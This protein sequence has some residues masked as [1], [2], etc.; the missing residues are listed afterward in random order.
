[1]DFE[2]DDNSKEIKKNGKKYPD[3][4]SLLKLYRKSDNRKAV[5]QL[6]NTLVPYFCLW[7]LMILSIRFKFPYYCTLLLA[8]PSS[9]F[10]VRIFILFHDCVHGSF[11]TSRKWNK[12]LGYILGVLVFTS[13][14]DWRFSHLKHHAN[15]GNLDARGYG[16]IWTLT[17]SEYNSLTCKKKI[18]YRLYRTPA[19]FILLGGFYT[20]FLGNRFPEKRVKFKDRKGVL[21]T[22]LIILVI[23]VFLSF[24]IGVKTYLLI[25]VPVLW[26]AGMAG[27]W[28][29]YVQ[30][31]FEGVYWA[32]ESE[33]DLF[34]A[35]MEG[36]SFYKLPA[37]L[38]WFSGNIG[39]HH[40]HHL[41]PAIPNYFL[42]KCYD[43][44]PPLQSKESLSISKSLH[45]VRLKIW[46]ENKGEL[47]AF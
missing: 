25:Q 18:K 36:C 20:F 41:S 11:V 1:M 15:F 23:V 31:Q 47:S 30:H 26:L 44:I 17:L 4:Y 13:F 46:D 32:R 37:V 34:R 10:L 3:W 19:V 5:L 45:C 38:R 12:I 8:V 35:S 16:D 2:I 43:A 27:I 39:Y 28:L 7:V 6:V 22:D 29:F 24:F 40:I 42:K 33:W 9:A 21:Y 14:D